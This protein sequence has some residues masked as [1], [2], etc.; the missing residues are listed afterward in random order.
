[1]YVY[2]PRDR[3][4]D[5]LVIVVLERKDVSISDDG[6]ALS[7]PNA[8]FDVAPVSELG[9]PLLSRSTMETNSSGSGGEDFRNQ[10]VSIVLMIIETG[11]HFH[12]E[13]NSSF[14][15]HGRSGRDNIVELC[16]FP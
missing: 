5:Y 11:A 13:R 9:V 2:T 1:M 3:I 8:F 14:G 10:L 15:Q 4:T 16:L 6:L 12:R 7:R